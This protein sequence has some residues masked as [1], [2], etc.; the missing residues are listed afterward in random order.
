MNINKKYKGIVY[1]ILSAFC[2]ATMNTFVKLSGDLP[3]MQKSFFRNFVAMLFAFMILM[4]EKDGFHYEKKNIPLLIL[5]SIL[6]T[7]GILCNYY[8]VDHLVLSDASMLGKLAPF[9]VIIFSAIFLHEKASWV[10]KICVVVAFVGSLFIIKPSFDVTQMS[11]SMIGVIGAM[12]AGGAYTCVRKLGSMGE[13]GPRIVFFFSSFSCLVCVPYLLT[14]YVSMSTTQ[15]VYLLLAGLFAAGGQFSV[16]AA[17]TYA[18][19]KEISVFD[20]SQ[21][22]FAAIMGFVLF[23]QVPDAF[24]FLGYFIICATAI[25]MF[26]YTQKLEK[27]K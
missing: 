22:V 15:L 19:A 8:A 5:R 18:P 7:I 12:G 4:K 9:F 10:Q 2:F 13:K 21:V 14:S 26:I 16:T 17:Y 6:G 23:G 27:N 25:A 24:S 20:Y 3:S 1:I 11:A